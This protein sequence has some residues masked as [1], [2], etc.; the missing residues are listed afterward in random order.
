M[1]PLRDSCT[2]RPMTLAAFLSG[3]P[4]RPNPG[5]V[6]PTEPGPAP[7]AIPDGSALPLDLAAA[8]ARAV[9]AVR[10]QTDP[11]AARLD[12]PGASDEWADESWL[13]AFLDTW[14]DDHLDDRLAAIARDAGMEVLGA[15]NGR[16]ALVVAPGLVVKVAMHGEGR[17]ATGNEV[18][19][20]GRATEA[21]AR[22]LMPLL[23]AAPDRSWCLMPLSEGPGGFAPEPP[24]ASQVQRVPP[25]PGA[26]DPRPLRPG[27]HRA[28]ATASRAPAPP[29]APGN[30]PDVEAG[31][32]GA[33]HDL[34]RVDRRV[35]VGVL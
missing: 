17:D 10:V 28:H 12:A 8:I 18:W 9:A 23:A 5:F 26:P 29:H 16:C 27:P 24:A 35:G 25:N 6:I 1:T 19:H 20:W 22:W 14:L 7:R 3:Q 2:V 33:S 30:E 13:S 15:G 21:E 32:E 4:P 31:A 34:K 11:I